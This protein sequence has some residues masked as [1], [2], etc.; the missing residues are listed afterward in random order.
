[1][2]DH[3]LCQVAAPMGNVP[4]STLWMNLI[5][6]SGTWGSSFVFVK[7]ITQSMHPFAFAASRGFIAMSALLAWLV[8]RRRTL[9]ADDTAPPRSPWKNI[10]H[11]VVLGTT[12]GWLA[13]VLIATAVSRVDSAVVAMLQASVP[14][15]VAVL[16]HFL[17]VE[18]PFRRRQLIGIIT[19][20]IGILLIVGP[21]AVFGGRGTLI[22]IAA[23]VLTAL[24]Y[25]CGTV[26]GRHIAS[27]NPAALACGQQACGAV[28][29]VIISLLFEPLAEWSQ[30]GTEWLLLAI[31]GVICS[32][33]PTALYLRLLARTAS[34]PAALVAYLQPVWATLLG[35]AILGEQVRGVALLG[36]GI[37]VI[38]IVV[39]TRKLPS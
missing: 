26:Y 11:M 24:S 8:L 2:D 34:V 16:A 3:L 21:V 30:S 22:G 36:T 1:L 27:T 33:V 9:P 29:A 10:G 23:M 14:L 20:L 4:L 12:N 15:M 6:I 32:A 25:A 39:T 38:G 7:L 28:L 5:I 18:E 35:W 13:N 31:V 37:V 17:F 19:G